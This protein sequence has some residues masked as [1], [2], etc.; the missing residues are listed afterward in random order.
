MVSSS[1]VPATT[2]TKD[3]PISSSDD[4]EEDLLGQLIYNSSRTAQLRREQQSGKSEGEEELA[5][6]QLTATITIA[7]PPNDPRVHNMKSL[8]SISDK[9]MKSAPK[10]KKKKKKRVQKSRKSFEQ[11]IDDLRA[12]KEKHG[13]I[14]VKKKEDKNLYEFCKKMR[15]ARKH[16]E[17]S[18][19]ALTDDRI[20]SSDALGF[21]WTVKKQA[22]KSFEQR[23]ENLKSYKEEHG[24]TNVKKGDD[25][26]LNKFCFHMRY[27]RN[28]PEKS[29]TVINDDRIASLD[30]LGF[31]WSMNNGFDRK[32]LAESWPR[33]KGRFVK[34]APGE[35]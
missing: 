33:A 27:A 29:N 5:P 24:H 16:P 10:K 11:R 32:K 6:Q 2:A 4:D 9:A 15:W 34:V 35:R 23:V 8:S 30:A 21:E 12:Y 18:T 17:K 7:N 13:H 20:A 26:S 25:K 28:H 22:D 19:M 31:E 14:N 1:A 3:D